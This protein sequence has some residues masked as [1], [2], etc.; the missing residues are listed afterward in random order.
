MDKA[1]AI[2]GGL[3]KIAAAP[4]RA[5]LALL[6][7]CLLTYLPGILRLPAVDRTEVIFAETTR[8]MLARGALT[9]PRYDGTVHAFRPIGTFWA[10]GIP[11][12]LA[13]EAHAHDIRVYRIPGLI[14]VTL[15]VLA[16]YWLSLPLVG[17]WPAFLAAGLFAVAPLT[18]LLSQLAIADGLALLPATVA[19]L[20]L[21]R[22]YVAGEK[23]DTRTLALL[24][25]GALGLG[26]FFNALHAPILVVVTLIALSFFDRDFWWIGRLHSARY[27]P[28]AVLL[29]APWLAVRF[30]QD[31]VP[32]SG[33]GFKKFLAALGGAQDMKLRAFPGTFLLAAVL[34][35]L[36]GTALLYPALKRLT[37]NRAEKLARFLLAW[38]VGYI[39]YLELVSSKPG[40]YTVQVMFPA[41]ALAVA[42]LVADWKEGA[43]APSGHLIPSPVLALVFPVPP[44]V[45][46]YAF[47]GVMPGVIAAVLISATARLFYLSAKAAR[48]C[49]PKR[50][51]MTGIAALSLLSIAF[52]AAVLPSIDRIWPT[53]E[54]ERALEGCPSGPVAV[55]GFREPSAKFMLKSDPAIAEPEALR[56]ALV[57]GRPSYIAGEARDAR[58][59]ALNRFQYRRPR[60]I[61]CVEAYNVMRGCPLAFTIISAGDTAGCAAV[62]K[63]PCNEAFEAYTAA[64]KPG[65]SCD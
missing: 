41:M 44:V 35:F 36:P 24:F 5:S 54:I 3:G 27:A 29:G 34:G 43:P 50:W 25:W 64:I 4:K 6:A 8:D 26:M 9:D 55:L 59:K 2:I 17:A 14:A 58:L 57:E 45:V 62:E 42:S 60:S 51:A 46:A 32:F 33:L 15:S 19:M 31:G 47:G 7:L 63:F 18:V 52:N 53:R 30:H 20:S 65:T 49:E 28:L 12:A 13:G 39:I 22:I 40:T 38:I 1:G 16:L 56:A 48:G 61:A 10:Q 11:A 23:D 21:L 37:D